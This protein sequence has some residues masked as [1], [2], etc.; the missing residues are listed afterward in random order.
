MRYI[1]CRISV[2]YSTIS[3][4]TL[5]NLFGVCTESEN[6]AIQTMFGHAHLKPKKR[7]SSWAK[8]AE[9]AYIIGVK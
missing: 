6:S 9:L 7:A 3:M 4:A 1:D 5:L 2:A 8:L